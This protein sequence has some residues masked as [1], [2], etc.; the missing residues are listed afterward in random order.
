[1]QHRLSGVFLDRVDRYN[2]RSILLAAIG[3]CWSMVHDI[4]IGKF[5]SEGVAK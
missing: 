4:S 2:L 1:M 5:R 3:Q